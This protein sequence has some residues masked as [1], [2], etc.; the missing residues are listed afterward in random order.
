M[1]TIVYRYGTRNHWVPPDEVIA[2]MRLANQ[3]RNRLVEIERDHDA[4][5]LAM[6]SEHPRVAEAE[7][8]LATAEAT[9]SEL[10]DTAK[11]Q[12]QADRSRATRPAQGKA[13]A[14]ARKKLS[15]ARQA[16]R[17]A[18]TTVYEVAK[19]KIEAIRNERKVAIKATYAE[20]SQT[21][22]LYWATYNAVTA[23]HRTATT[24]VAASRKK[25]LPAERK[26][27]RFDGSGTITVQLQR[28][29]K[30]P[31]RSPALLSSGEGPWRNIARLP[32][33]SAMDPA[34]H[35]TLSRGKRRRIGRDEITLALGSGHTVTIPIQIHRPLP[36][37]ADV[38]QIELTSRRVASRYETA[39]AIT[40]KIP[41]PPPPVAGPAIAV[42]LGW[43][44]LPD[45]SVRVATIKST[46]TLT[47]PTNLDG[48]VVGSSTQLEA[49]IPA[50]LMDIAG[51]PASVRGRRDG[52]L[53]PRLKQLAEWI[54]RYPQLWENDD[55][56]FV[57]WTPNNIRQWRSAGRLA[58][59]AKAWRDNPTITT[60]DG[61][62]ELLADLEAWRRQDK[63]LWEWEANERQQTARYR[64]ELWR[65][66]G[67]WLAS[68]ASVVVV[69]DTNL[70]QLRQRMDIG[71]TDPITPGIV[72]DR[73][74]A[75][76]VIA[77]PGRLREMIV[78]A[79]TRR[80]V[81]VTKVSAAGLSR[82]H[83]RCGHENTADARFATS[84]SVV[85]DGCGQLYDQ[86]R[87]AVSLMLTRAVGSSANSG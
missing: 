36:A 34:E 32:K 33:V 42:H 31:K 71:E 28:E 69:D 48:C 23:H 79:A 65:R 72:A 83:S 68:Q 16:R 70:A 59:V 10:V 40:V 44:T 67:A 43:R 29:A 21:N 37:D 60:L 45:G 47:P 55:A 64:D 76:A 13:I 27:R 52:N 57:R 9:V 17:A 87:N 41:D 3:L 66:V 73:A 74:R 14:A 51:R 20:Y 25:G 11:Q 4:A 19:S 6:W 12:H 86:D 82:I 5:M 56:P 46:Q 26:F 58:A 62:N 22:G 2:Q 63:H 84:I 30:A 18:I 50:R 8:E 53:T 61:G 85:C 54:E 24:R 77:A 7:A 15:A 78:A 1:S 81:D 75:R 49:V 39:V 35:A 38:C 80:G